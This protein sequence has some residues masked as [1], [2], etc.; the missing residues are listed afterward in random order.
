MGDFVP[1]VGEYKYPFLFFT[2][3]DEFLENTVHIF[4]P[5]PVELLVLELIRSN[6]ADPVKV[7][8]SIHPV[9]LVASGCSK[10]ERL[11]PEAAEQ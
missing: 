10:L 8:F 5:H 7:L 11:Q 3:R 4:T 9:R 2:V 1:E 6:P